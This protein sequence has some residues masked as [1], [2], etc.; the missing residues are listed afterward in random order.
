MSQV[1]DDC[2]G[3]YI[4]LVKKNIQ[5]CLVIVFLYNLTN[6]LQ[7]YKKVIDVRKE[8]KVYPFVLQDVFFLAG[9]CDSLLAQYN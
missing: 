3:E 1:E 7:L 9:N 6:V 2:K 5:S 4:F 8:N